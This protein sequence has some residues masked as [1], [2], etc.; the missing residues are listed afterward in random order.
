MEHSDVNS[1]LSASISDWAAIIALALTVIGW[2]YQAYQTQKE[3]KRNAINE[4]H[5]A[6]L[7]RLEDTLHEIVSLVASVPSLEHDLRRQADLE[8]QLLVS[9]SIRM[10]ASINKVGKHK[11]DCRRYSQTIRRLA[12]LDTNLEKGNIHITLINLRRVIE[13]LLSELAKIF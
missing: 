11:V 2:W 3:N 12:T 6:L 10:L 5:N 9:R 7:D 1:C 4:E 8:I 13:A